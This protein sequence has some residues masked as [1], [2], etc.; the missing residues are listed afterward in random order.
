MLLNG[1]VA[2]TDLTQDSAIK[3]I[4]SMALDQ[5]NIR[6]PKLRSVKSVGGV[7]SR[8]DLMALS[9]LLNEHPNR[10]AIFGSD[11]KWELSLPNEAFLDELKAGSRITPGFMKRGSET[12]LKT[13]T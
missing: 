3:D 1:I 13:L 8:K 6:L 11:S 12:L 7:L 5:I 2:R 9:Y 4:G 10:E